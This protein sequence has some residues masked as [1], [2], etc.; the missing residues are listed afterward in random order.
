MR[1]STTHVKLKKDAP[2]HILGVGSL[3]GITMKRLVT[4]ITDQHHLSLT[5]VA[6]RSS[7]GGGDFRRGDTEKYFCKLAKRRGLSGPG[8]SH[9]LAAYSGK[10]DPCATNCRRHWRACC[11]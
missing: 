11:P 5:E 4:P 10:E 8:D 6:H 9:L 7:T 1:L 3:R 2:I